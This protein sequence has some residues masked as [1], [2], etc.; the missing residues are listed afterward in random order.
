M[1]SLNI[2]DRRREGKREYVREILIQRSKD[3][4]CNT[5]IMVEGDKRENE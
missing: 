5:E 2:R 3:S 1:L 4:V